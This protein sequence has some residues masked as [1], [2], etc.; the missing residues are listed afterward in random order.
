[1]TIRIKHA[2]SAAT[3][4]VAAYAS[5][6]MAATVNWGTVSTFT[7]DTD[8]DLSGPVVWAVNAGQDF[9]G[10]GGALTIDGNSANFEDVNLDYSV[11]GSDFFAEIN[12]HLPGSGASIE[13]DV[14]NTRHP[15]ALGTNDASLVGACAGDETCRTYDANSG[16]AVLDSFLASSV[17]A[18]ARTVGDELNMVLNGLVIGQTYSI[19]LVSNT[20]RLDVFQSLDD[21]TGNIL[22]GFN[23]ALS[24]GTG[25]SIVTGLFIADATSQTIDVILDAGRNPGVSLA[26]LS[27]ATV[28]PIPAAAWLFGSALCGLSILRRKKIT[29]IFD[30]SSCPVG[31]IKEV[32]HL[33]FIPAPCS[34]HRPSMW[35]YT[36]TNWRRELAISKLHNINSLVLN[37]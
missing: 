29:R 33:F 15:I 31:I 6:G 21:G 23:G 8:I 35:R 30:T 22:S 3:L 34:H 32:K 7:T 13:F 11:F 27:E 17:F 12:D 4:L 16:N 28:V 26:V 20:S 1:M 10:G 25:P 2:T 36:R 24:D 5:T 14:T 19:Q 37:R 9:L 18:D